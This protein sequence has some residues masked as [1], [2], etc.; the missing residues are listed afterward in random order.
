L[1]IIYPQFEI[2]PSA[3]PIGMLNVS[4]YLYIS[5]KTMQAFLFMDVGGTCS[6]INISWL[7]V[8]WVSS[9]I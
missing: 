3:V 1:E 4:N 9:L 7:R 2:L 5:W 6:C 8:A